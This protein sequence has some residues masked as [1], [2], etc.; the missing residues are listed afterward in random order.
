MD[1]HRKKAVT[2][3]HY[4][5]N[6]GGD[7]LTTLQE[8]Q[9]NVLQGIAHALLDVADAIRGQSRPSVVVQYTGETTEELAAKIRNSVRMAWAGLR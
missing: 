1:D 4:A 7:Y 8:A 9:L 3:I 2:A 5:E 6:T